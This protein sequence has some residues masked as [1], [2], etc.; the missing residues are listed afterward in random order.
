VAIKKIILLGLRKMPLSANEVMVMKRHRSP[1]VVNYLDSY[2]V[3]GELW[4]VMEHMDGGTL[5]DVIRMTYLS[6]D[7]MAAISRECLQGLDFLHS[8]C[9]F[10]RDIKSWVSIFL[11]RRSLGSRDVRCGAALSD[12]QLP[13][14]GAGWQC[15]SP[16]CELRT[17]LQCAQRYDTEPQAVKSGVALYVKEPGGASC[18]LFL[19]AKLL[20]AR[21][22]TPKLKQPEL[23]SAWLHDFLSCCLQ[24]DEERRWSAQELLH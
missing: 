24:T 14:N 11:V 7:E 10:H 23:L 5:H 13:K 18:F 3:D 22:G 20:I 16:R 15:R 4:L 1:C 2:L 21:E 17:R 19:Q 8:N 9:V 12:C 6:E